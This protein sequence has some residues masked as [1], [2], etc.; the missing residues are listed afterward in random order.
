MLEWLSKAPRETT[1]HSK[2]SGSSAIPYRAPL[3]WRSRVLE[4]DS[5][6]EITS[7]S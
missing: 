7:H 5:R 4:A 6:T 1:L 2:Q 3:T